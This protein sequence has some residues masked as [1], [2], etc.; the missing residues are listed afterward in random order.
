V[1]ANFPKQLQMDRLDQIAALP[2]G[3][4]ITLDPWSDRI[5]LL[6]TK[7]VHPLSASEKMPFEV[8]PFFPYLKRLDGHGHDK[9]KAETQP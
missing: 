4:R 7:P 3:S 8:S 6:K 5:E 9:T 2:L 1:L